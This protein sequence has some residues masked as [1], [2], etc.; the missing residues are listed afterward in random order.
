MNI[1]L[2]TP[3]VKEKRI[4]WFLMLPAIVLPLVFSTDVLLLKA[5]YYLALAAV[6]VFVFR[7]FLT[8]SFR[9][10]PGNVFPFLWKSVLMFIA[11]QLATLV[12][13]DIFLLFDVGMFT[14]G[15]FGPSM[16]TKY[17]LYW[18]G[19]LPQSPWIGITLIILILPVLQEILLRGLLFGSVCQ[20][21]PA[22]A[23]LLTTVVFALIHTVPYLDGCTFEHILVMS[24]QYI[25]AG[26]ALTAA[27]CMTESIYSPIVI[28]IAIKAWLVFSYM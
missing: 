18:L 12:I 10:L 23:F 6:T 26:I 3:L 27:Y 7:A 11:A 15:D 19:L 24:V 16:V 25:P 14:W 22:L 8:D 5:L 4:G 13:N 28:H 21:F 17:D 20:R 9:E 2:V 1:M